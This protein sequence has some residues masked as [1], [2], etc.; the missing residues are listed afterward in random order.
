MLISVR[1]DFKVRNIIRNKEGNYTMIKQLILQEDII[2][3][4]N[5]LN[6]RMLICMRNK[7]IE[8]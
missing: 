6:N 8:F 4:F 3:K 5:A 2:L 1:A 7:L